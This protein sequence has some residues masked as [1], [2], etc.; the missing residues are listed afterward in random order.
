[1]IIVPTAMHTL[2]TN[3]CIANKKQ[4]GQ[5]TLPLIS[6]TEFTTDSRQ[7]VEEYMHRCLGTPP[8]TV[9]DVITYL[10]PV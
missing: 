4:C 5:L 8:A 9:Q 3:N 10:F 6:S 2:A 1:M 7:I